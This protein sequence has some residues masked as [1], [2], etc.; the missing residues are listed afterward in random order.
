MPLFSVKRCPVWN[1]LAALLALATTLSAAPWSALVSPDN[2]LE[3]RFL[4][5]DAAVFRL[6]LAGWGPNWQWVGLGAK[7]KA[8]G[9]RLDLSVPF[10]V[11]Q[12]DGPGHRHP[13]PGLAERAA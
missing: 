4:R 12:A 1:G 11:N 5:D 3:F 2:S 7:Q 13:V 9:D 10:V 6:S 8:S